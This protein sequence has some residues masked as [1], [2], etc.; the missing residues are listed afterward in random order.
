M[1]GFT[2]LRKELTALLIPE[3][4]HAPSKKDFT[5]H[6]AEPE[7]TLIH[8]ACGTSRRASSAWD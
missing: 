4:A 7:K 5:A 2:K 1:A 8:A 3:P 6:Q